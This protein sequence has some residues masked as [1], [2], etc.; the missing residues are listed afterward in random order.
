MWVRPPPFAPFWGE[1]QRGRMDQ[2]ISNPP[3]LIARRPKSQAGTSVIG[4]Y[5]LTREGDVAQTNLQRQEN[6]NLPPLARNRTLDEIATLRLDDMFKNQY[7][8]HVSPASSS[9]LTVA[10]RVGDNYIALG[11]NLA[12]GD[13]EGDSGVVDAWMH[14][15]GHRANILNTHYTEIGVAV[16]G[17]MLLGEDGW[18]AVQVFGRPASDCP[19]PDASLKSTLNTSQTELSQMQTRLQTLQSEMNAMQPQNGPDYNQAVDAY[20]A[21]AAQY[22]AL[23]SQMKSETARYNAEVGAYNECIKE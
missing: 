8:A 7:F 22:N 2:G 19:I 21:L 20:N 5:T 17:G 14:S 10:K 11:E 13:F 4:Q 6:G 16:G 18:L 1:W 12:L 3:P 23:V 9:A 15:P